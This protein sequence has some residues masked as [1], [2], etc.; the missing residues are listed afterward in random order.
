[1]IKPYFSDMINNHKTPKNVRFH[2]SNEVI[3]YET[4]FGE[5]KIQLTMQINSIS[6]KDS[7]ET[8][9][10]HTKSR[11]IEIMMR[12]KTNDIIEELR[13]CLLQNYQEEE[14]SMRGSQFVRDSI[15]L[16]YYHLQKISLKRARSYIDSLKQ[17]KNKRAT[18][19]PKNNDNNCFQYALTV[20]LNYQNI[21][22]V[23]QK[24]SKFK[25]FIDQYNWKEIDFP[26]HSKDWKKFEQNNKT[27]ALNILFVPYN[28]EKIRLAYKSKHN[29]KRENQVILLMITDGKIWHY[30]TVSIAQRNNIK[31]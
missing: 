30:L 17:L 26:S 6:S 11:N 1:M 9:T 5:W 24:I 18:I 31:S 10:M 12:S 27:I 16:L 23:L 19:I 29:F 13:K 2:P 14:K 28:T 15:D 22:K 21:K 20:A 4:Q 8:R 7:G 25:P 3:D